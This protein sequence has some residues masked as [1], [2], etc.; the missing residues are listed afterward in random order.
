MAKDPG[1][2]MYFPGNYRWSSAFINMIGSAPYGGS[3]FGELHK[4]GTLLKDKGA[5]GRRRRGSTRARRWPTA[6]ARYAEKFEGAGH[7]HSAAAR[8]SAR[9]QLLPDGRALPHAQGRE[10]ARRSTSTGVQCFHRFAKLTDVNIELVEVPFEGGSLP[11]LFRARAER[12][13]AAHAVRRV[14]R[15]PRRHQGDP[16]HARRARSH[17]ARHLGA[18]HGR[19]GHG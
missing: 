17:Q 9:V 12:E 19:P 13:I 3:E 14:L 18:R 8:L 16:V 10:G 4:I 2:F 11:G 5:R 15:R 6:C 7:R 1:Y